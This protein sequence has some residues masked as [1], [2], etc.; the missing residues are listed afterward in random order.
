MKALSVFLRLTQ[1]PL[2]SDG[3]RLRRHAHGPKGDPRPPA[4]LLARHRVREQ[5]IHGFPCYTVAQRST[6]PDAVVMYIHGGAYVNEIV[7]QHW[8][9]ISRLADVGLVVQVPIYGLAPQYTFREAYGFLIE[10]YRHIAAN[11]DAQRIQLMGDSSG[12]GLALG[13]AQVLASAGRPPPRSLVLISPWLDIR[14]NNPDIEQVEPHDPWLA[15]AGAQAAGQL[16]ANGADAADPLLSPVN[17]ELHGLPPID[18][19]I[20]THDILYPDVMV[21]VR[22]ARHSGCM[23]DLTV[24]PGAFHVYPLAPVWE[25]IEAAGRIVGRAADICISDKRFST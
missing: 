8:G 22:R 5:L 4:W 23:V 9:L 2:W 21:L 15:K 3:Q 6:V 18:V 7:G 13:L 16:W 1:K 11:H 20:G 25:G 17:G 12:G 14:C 10:V 24:C 19:Y